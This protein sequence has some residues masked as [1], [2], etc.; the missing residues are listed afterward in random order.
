M[1]GDD[2]LAILEGHTRKKLVAIKGTINTKSNRIGSCAVQE[3]NVMAK[4]IVYGEQARQAVRRGVNQVADGME[5]TPSR[6]GVVAT[7]IPGG[8]A[9]DH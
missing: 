2:V 1:K 7:P 3:T 8:S 6:H 9:Y 4:Q 5:V